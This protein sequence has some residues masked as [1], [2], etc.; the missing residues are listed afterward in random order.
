MIMSDKKCQWQED[1]A[2]DTLCGMKHQF[3]ADGPVENGYKYCPYCG[4]EIEV[5]EE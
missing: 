5:V 2:F 1:V 3:M 4:K